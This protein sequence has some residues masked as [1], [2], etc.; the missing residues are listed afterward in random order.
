MDRLLTEIEHF[1]AWAGT[2][3]P[4]LSPAEIGG[5]W[6][7]E[8]LGWDG[9]TA[10]FE[11][12]LDRRLPEEFTDE[13]LSQLVYI[14]ARDNE[15]EV[16]AQM[17]SEREAWFTALCRLSLSL[18][19]PEARWQLAIRLPAMADRTMAGQ[20]LEQFVRDQDEYV[21]RRAVM[22]MPALLPD[23]VEHYASI[24]WERNCW[25]EL[26]EYQ[27]MAVLS[28]LADAG[29][30]LLGK[31]LNMARADGR[32]YLVRYAEEISSKYPTISST[33]SR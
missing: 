15:C 5:E 17:A 24:F 21:S 28:A 27:R 33:D 18:S 29:S 11:D 7:T 9:I 6:E 12:A 10:A 31:Y 13:V 25:G 1:R 14:I 16:L 30:P 26:Q 19:E 3:F 8:Y 4:G 22:V 23:K 2:A 32:P 20:L